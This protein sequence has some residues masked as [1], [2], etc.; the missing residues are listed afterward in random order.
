MTKLVITF[1][2]WWKHLTMA[3]KKNTFQL[4]CNWILFLLTPGKFTSRLLPR[5]Y[6]RCEFSILR[7]FLSNAV[8]ARGL[9]GLTCKVLFNYHTVLKTSLGYICKIWKHEEEVMTVLRGYYFPREWTDF[10][11]IRSWNPTLQFTNLTKI[12]FIRW[13]QNDY[14]SKIEITQKIDMVK[15]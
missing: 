12:A 10:Y 2:I 8:V 13:H 9:N 7:F 14:F 15:V 3:W 5:I 6:S 1:A 4:R 11:G